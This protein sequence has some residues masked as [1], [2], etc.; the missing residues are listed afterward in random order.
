MKDIEPIELAK[1]ELKDNRYRCNLMEECLE[2]SNRDPEKAENLYIQ[3]K[4]EE[5]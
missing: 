4:Y 5:A 1:Q 3:K 2:I